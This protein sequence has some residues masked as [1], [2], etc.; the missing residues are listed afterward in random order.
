M[1]GVNIWEENIYTLDM[2]DKPEFMAQM[3]KINIMS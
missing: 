1:C 2:R 3:F